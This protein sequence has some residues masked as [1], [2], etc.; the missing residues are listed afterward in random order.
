MN[1]LFNHI[2]DRF[3]LLIFETA[4]E[5]IAR[6]E[7]E[8][9][10]LRKEAEKYKKKVEKAGFCEGC[11]EGSKEGKKLRW[12]RNDEFYLC[13]DCYYHDLDCEASVMVPMHRATEME[14][15]ISEGEWDELWEEEVN[16]KDG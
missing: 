15:Y 4:Q 5:Y 6:K 3:E 12:V 16:K 11:G 14:G 9:E 10:K 1:T 13:Y 8:K 7:K 2:E